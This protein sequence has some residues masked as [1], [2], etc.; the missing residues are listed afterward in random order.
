MSAVVAPLRDTVRLERNFWPEWPMISMI[1]ERRSCGG[2]AVKNNRADEALTINKRAER[3]RQYRQRQKA[4][5]SMVAVELDFDLIEALIEAGLLQDR[6]SENRV[7]VAAAIGAVLDQWKNTVM[8]NAA[9]AAA[10][11]MMCST[12]EK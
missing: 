2:L 4:Q 5:K 12:K 1:F 8:H 9:R 11:R 10:W 3:Q 6:H 7:S